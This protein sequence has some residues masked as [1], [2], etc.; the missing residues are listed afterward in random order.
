MGRP[1]YQKII[2]LAL[3][4][5]LASIFIYSAPPSRGVKKDKPLSQALLNIEGWH[6]S[7]VVPLEQEIVKV[8]GLDEYAN[9]SYSNGRET[10]F[11]YIGYYLTKKKLGAAHDPLVCFPGGGWVASEIKEGSL[12]VSPEVNG[13]I[14]FSTMTVER[15]LRKE[16]ILYWFQSYDRTASNTFNQKIISLRQ[17]TLRRREDNA[18]VR[19]SIP[20]GDKSLDECREILTQ[21]IKSFYPLFLNYVKG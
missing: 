18:F 7:G 16:F 10:V 13:S 2:V 20:V 4:F 19:I 14:S 9:Q 5:G 21:F 3:L 8:L 6:S 15:G 1:L 17:R 11:L 12:I